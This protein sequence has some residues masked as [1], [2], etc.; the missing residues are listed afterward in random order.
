MKLLIHSQ[1]LTFVL[2]WIWVMDK[3]F[4]PTLHRACD[5]L[6]MLGFKLKGPVSKPAASLHTFNCIFVKKNMLYQSKLHC[7]WFLMGHLAI[8][9][10]WFGSWLGSKQAP[11]HYLKQ[12]WRICLT[13]YGVTWSQWVNLFKK[14]QISLYICIYLFINVQL[15]QPS[16]Y[17]NITISRGEACVESLHGMKG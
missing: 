16:E 10:H 9:E 14:W 15:K 12:F 7:G 3:W 13:P 8:N 1:T 17:W 5:Y 4:H 6:S 11:S 2:R